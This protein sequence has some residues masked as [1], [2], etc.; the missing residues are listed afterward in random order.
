MP[1]G[2]IYYADNWNGYPPGEGMYYSSIGFD[3]LGFIVE[4]VSSLPFEEYCRQYIFEPLQMKNTSFTLQDVPLEQFTSIY[5]YLSGVHFPLP[6]YEI[7]N[8]GSG[9]VY[10][11]VEDISHFLRAHMNNGTY[12]NA[13]ILSPTTI[14]LMHTPQ[15]LD[16]PAYDIYKDGRKYGFG[17]IIWPDE[18]LNYENG[19]QGHLGNVPGGLASMTVMNQNGVVFFGNEWL[20]ISYSQTFIMGFIREYLHTKNKPI[21]IESLEELL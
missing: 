2:M 12:E 15:T 21:D 10:T 20:T 6:Y 7:I 13:Q 9:G 4:R 5:G 18:Q 1:G 16:L 8:D 17:W 14:Q 19:L 3:L 11:T